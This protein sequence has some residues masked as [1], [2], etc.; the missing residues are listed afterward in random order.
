ME[1]ERPSQ[2]DSNYTSERTGTDA[3][4]RTESLASS[5]DSYR[6]STMTAAEKEEERELE[7]EIQE[8]KKPKKPVARI[9]PAFIDLILLLAQLAVF[10]GFLYMAYF[11]GNLNDT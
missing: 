8:E 1:F 2:Q 6:D 11:F 3:S 7:R 4:G 10:G 5:T 9:V